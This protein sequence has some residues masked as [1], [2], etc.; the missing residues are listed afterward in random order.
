MDAL[1]NSDSYTLESPFCQLEMTDIPGMGRKVE[2]AGGICWI[3]TMDWL[4]A[5]LQD[6]AFVVSKFSVR[7]KYL[8]NEKIASGGLNWKDAYKQYKPNLTLGASTDSGMGKAACIAT[9]TAI[10][11]GKG[12]LLHL[13]S[14]LD[15]MNADSHAI[16]IVK[17]NGGYRMF[18]SN[19]G[20]YS[21]TS[22]QKCAR[23][24]FDVCH[25]R[26]KN[27]K[28]YANLLPKMSR[29]IFS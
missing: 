24:I 15:N 12:A 29:V 26:R 9:A 11:L 3:L 16:G 13:G 19:F 27:N 25:H 4:E 7:Q 17:I 23:W 10:A 18:D 28:V 1:P 20:E 5:R 2:R 8:Q 6:K 22:L 21:T 14:G